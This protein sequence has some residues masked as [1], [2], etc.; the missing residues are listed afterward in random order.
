M[1]AND[2]FRYACCPAAH[3]HDGGSS[4][5]GSRSAFSFVPSGLRGPCRRGPKHPGTNDHLLERDAMATLFFLEQRE[6]IFS[7]GGRY[8]LMLVAMMRR[9][10]VSR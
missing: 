4:G 7:S 9:I 1:Q 6:G 8:S 3:Q 10:A 5:E 2:R